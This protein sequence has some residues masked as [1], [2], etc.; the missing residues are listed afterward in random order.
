MPSRTCRRFHPGCVDRLGRHWVSFQWTKP[1]RSLYLAPSALIEPTRWSVQY[2]GVR[3][4][5]EDTRSPPALT[6]S[7][8]YRFTCHVQPARFIQRINFLFINLPTDRSQRQPIARIHL[9]YRWHPGRFQ[10]A[11]CRVMG[12]S[13][14]RKLQ[15][16]LES[17]CSNSNYPYS[18]KLIIFSFAH[19]ATPSWSSS[20]VLN[21]NRV[22]RRD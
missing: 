2:C 6:R 12:P 17:K 7:Y 20:R 22:R 18:R 5:P 15:D 21:K 9:R 10:R 19:H 11:P 14:P 8:P 13:F 3:T 16:R 4:N 1:R